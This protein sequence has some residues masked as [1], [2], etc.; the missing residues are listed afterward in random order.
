MEFH[1]KNAYLI[2]VTK[3]VLLGLVQTDLVII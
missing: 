3:K 1:T 2:T